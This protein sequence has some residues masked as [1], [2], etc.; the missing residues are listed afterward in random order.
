MA[1]MLAIP[2]PMPT[3]ALRPRTSAMYEAG[4]KDRKAPSEEAAI[5]RP[6]IFG[7]RGREIQQPSLYRREAIPLWVL[8]DV[9]RRVGHDDQPQH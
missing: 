2:E 3:Q 6:V 8:K 5:M 4:T 1:A 7:V 9:A